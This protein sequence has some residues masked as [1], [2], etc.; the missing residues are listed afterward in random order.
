MPPTYIADQGGAAPSQPS[1]FTVVMGEEF[2][3]DPVNGVD[4]SGRGRSLDSPA[5]TI[6]WV[7]DNLVES[8]DGDTIWVTPGTCEEQIT[9]TKDYVRVKG[10]IEGYGKPDI[11]SAAGVVL[12]VRAQGVILQDLRV[13]NDGVDADVIQIEGN[14]GRMTRCVVDGEATMG[15]TKALMRLWCHL[16]DDSYTAS[17]WTFENLMLRGSPGYGLAFDVQDAAVGVGPTHNVFRDVRFI[18]NTAEDVIALATAVGTYTVQDTLFERCHFGMGT[19][20]NKATHIDI[21]TNT[22]ATNTG[23]VFAFCSV[24]DD[25]V[26]GTAIKA[27]GTG[28]SFIGCYSLDGAINGD[29]LD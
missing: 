22:G 15:A 29:A 7:H 8:G 16:T 4:S 9:L 17:E 26:D 20:K 19:G 3:V 13:A 27:A 1:G 6:Q 18:S 12:I 10:L 21:S 5:A 24:N 14:G 25:T 28:S 11:V 23:N 2:F